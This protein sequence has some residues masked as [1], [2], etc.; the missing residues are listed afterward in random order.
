MVL[1]WVNRNEKR[2]TRGTGFPCLGLA[3]VQAHFLLSQWKADQ[4]KHK[5]FISSFLFPSPATQ[6]DLYEWK[7]LLHYF[8]INYLILWRNCWETKKKKKKRHFSLSVYLLIF[9]VESFFFFFLSL[10]YPPKER[11][12]AWRSLL[13][14]HKP[15]WIMSE[16]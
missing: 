6:T 3:H 12:D 4:N 16:L 10:S 8:L 11:R 5:S 14:I 9:L 15:L 2:T 7:Y 13:K 1:S